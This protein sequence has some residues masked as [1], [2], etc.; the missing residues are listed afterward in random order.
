MANQKDIDDAVSMACARNL[1]K[2]EMCITAIN[3]LDQAG[4]SVT[5]QGRVANLLVD[6]IDDFSDEQQPGE[7]YEE[8]C[9]RVEREEKRL[10][11]QM[12]LRVEV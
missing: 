1:S 10:D 7:S 6:E 12:H 9:E 3:L 4:I 5:V 11:D 8:C 2:R